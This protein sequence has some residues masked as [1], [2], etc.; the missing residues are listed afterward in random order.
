[1]DLKTIGGSYMAYARRYFIEMN[2]RSSRKQLDRANDDRKKL[3]TLV[4]DAIG[5]N[6]CWIVPTCPVGIAFPHNPSQGRLP[7]TSK[8]DGGKLETT[9]VPYWPMTLTFVMPFTVTGHP[10]VTM[11]LGTVDVGNNVQVP[12]GVQVVGKRGEDMELLKTCR[13]MEDLLWGKNVGPPKPP[14]CRDSNGDDTLWF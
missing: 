3:R 5:E 14:S 13:Q 6:D 1:M 12:I 9:M 10:V 11:P 4:D 7:F 8:K 2:G